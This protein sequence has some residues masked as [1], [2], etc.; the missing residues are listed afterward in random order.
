MT[1]THAQRTV[2][3]GDQWEIPGKLYDRDRTP[4]N[5]TGVDIEWA[6]SDAASGSDILTQ[7]D[8]VILITNAVHGEFMITADPQ[9]T[10]D[11]PPGHYVDTLRVT[12]TAIPRETMWTGAFIV[13]ASSFPLTPL[14]SLRV[15]ETADRM[16][17]NITIAGGALG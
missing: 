16:A 4:L 6:F 9:I 5:L 11:I 8:V 17:F 2:Y 3:A 12:A 13:R 1:T 15:T 14:A 10:T 7:D